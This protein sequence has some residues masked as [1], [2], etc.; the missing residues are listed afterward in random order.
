MMAQ[1]FLF[2]EFGVYIRKTHGP[3]IRLLWT[4]ENDDLGYR[5]LWK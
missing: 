4:I 3:G 1:F 5:R 2:F